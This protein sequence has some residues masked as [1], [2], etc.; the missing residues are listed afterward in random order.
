MSTLPTNLDL[1]VT[2]VNHYAVEM[3][4]QVGLFFATKRSENTIL[5]FELIQGPIKQELVFGKV[6]SHYTC[7]IYICMIKG[8]IIEAVICHIGQQ[9][10]F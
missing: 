9:K 4:N 10:L 5:N 7:L 1:S 6:Y 8:A 3:V 2:V